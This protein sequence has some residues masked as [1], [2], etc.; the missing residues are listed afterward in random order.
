MYMY[1]TDTQHNYVHYY[2]N[3]F[4][5]RQTTILATQLTVRKP[6]QFFTFCAAKQFLAYPTITPVMYMVCMYIPVNVTD[7]Q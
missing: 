3:A 4:S 2:L 1:S 5:L 7:A 6:L